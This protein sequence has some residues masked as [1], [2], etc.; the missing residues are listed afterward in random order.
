MSEVNLQQLLIFSL[1]SSFKYICAMK[2]FLLA[3]AFLILL[4]GTNNAQI[5]VN[6]DNSPPDNSAM[7]DI[8][9]ASRGLLIP[10][11]TLTQIQT[12]TNPVNSLLVFCTT[13]NKFYAY[14]AASSEWK[15][16]LFGEG[17][18]TPTC[19]T[20]F[21]DVRDGKTYNTIQIGT[22]CWMAQ[23]LNVGTR[24]NGGQG[25]GN[26]GTLEKYCYADLETNCDIYGGLYQ[27][28]EM[29]QFTTTPGVQG[30]CP[31]DWHLPT[32][33]EF[34]TL[35][36]WLGGLSDAGGKMKEAGTAHWLSP[37]TGATNESG[38][39]ILPASYRDYLGQFSGQLGVRAALWTSTQN[40]G[41]YGWDYSLFHDTD[42]ATRNNGAMKVNGFSVRCIK[43]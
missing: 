6:H 24:I 19:G 34:T 13:D 27:W 15:E 12:L 30:I 26:N 41:T 31:A 38:F 9:S 3:V 5:G 2:N 21:T 40:G 42:D 10:R 22:Q 1:F 11:L 8:K 17:E 36:T 28:N 43:N 20:P 23:N 16:L 25:Q 14:L 32:D 4:I 35:T 18:I 33:A 37:N 29:M 7:L 39:T